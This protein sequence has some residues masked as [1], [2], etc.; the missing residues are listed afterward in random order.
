VRFVPLGAVCVLDR[1]IVF[2]VFAEQFEMPER[3]ANFAD[4]SPQVETT[5][6]W[7]EVVPA[8]AVM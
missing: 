5:F 2:A 8:V 6:A 1:V 7:K 4:P 3:M